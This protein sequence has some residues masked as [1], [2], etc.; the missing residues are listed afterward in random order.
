MRGPVFAADVA[1]STL[2]LPRPGGSSPRQRDLALAPVPGRAAKTSGNGERPMQELSFTLTCRGCGTGFSRSIERPRS[3][4]Q[5]IILY[6]RHCGCPHQVEP[7]D[8]VVRE[9]WPAVDA[10][11][12]AT[13]THATAEAVPES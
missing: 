1:P 4:N 9:R 12:P 7:R 5:A 2:A 13:A 8:G 11:P 3:D 10:P 6:C